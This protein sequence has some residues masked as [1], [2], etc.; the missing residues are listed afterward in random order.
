M[1][2]KK[3]KLDKPFL[4]AEIGINHN[5]SIELTKK[6]IDLAKET[7]FDAVKFQKRDPEITTPDSQKFKI[8]QTPWGEM[9]YLQYKKKIE[10]QKK[11]YDSIARYCSSKKIIWF[12]SAWDIKSQN[13]LKRYKLK[14]NKVASAMLTNTKLLEVI[15]KE[16][17]ITFI[18]TGMSNM[19]EISNALRIFKKHKCKFV[20]MHCVSQ[21]PCPVERL[22]LNTIITLRNKFKCEIGYSGHESDVSSSMLAYFL[23]C[24]YIERHITLDR[25]MW[26][27]DQAASLSE[28]GMK[29]LSSALRK[30]PSMLGNG[31]KILSKQDTEML[32][33]FK[34]W[35]N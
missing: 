12:A 30:F 18:S 32:K 17:K 14:Y 26:G 15:A 11:E 6:L 23:G 3:L 20:L 8:R 21:Y 5:G 22:N 4:I 19:K 7:G 31:I 24:K 16:R 29:T 2:K 10:F 28:T 34:Y 9:T 27:T 1:I 13:F 35:K 33:K 25:S